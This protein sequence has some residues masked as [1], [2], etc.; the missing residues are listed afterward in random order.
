MTPGRGGSQGT[1]LSP[2]CSIG[3][4][5]LDVLTG[6]LHPT[7]AHPSLPDL[8]ARGFDDLDVTEILDGVVCRSE[9]VWNAE[10]STL[11]NT[12]MDYQQY[13]PAEA[14]LHCP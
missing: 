4:P 8:D 2:S 14:P 11:V 6:Y 9:H 7:P 10:V 13:D 1:R 5:G 12:V 3:L